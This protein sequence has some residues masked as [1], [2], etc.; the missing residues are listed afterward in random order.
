MKFQSYTLDPFQERAIR[1]LQRNETVIV[2][3]ATGTGKTLIAEYLIDTC[4]KNQRKRVVY[5]APIKARSNQKF[6]DFCS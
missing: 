3:A 4:I 1:Y 6:R 2:S 5:T